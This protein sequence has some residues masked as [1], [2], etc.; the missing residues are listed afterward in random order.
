MVR[1]IATV[2]A[3]VP[4]LALAACG[5]SDEDSSSQTADE[6]SAGP[7]T[8]TIS[9]WAQGTEGEALPEFLEEFEAENPDV[10]V[11]VTAIPWDSAQN[12]YQTAIAG[13]T[14]PDIGMLGTDWMP[15]F[16]D[17]LRPTPDEIDM[18]GM[19]PANVESTNL[20]GTH[21]G[22]PWYVETRVIFY[23]TDLME[24]AGFD[25]FPTTWDGFK[26][27]ARAMQEET[28]A[29]YGVNLPAGGWN[30]FLGLLPFAWSNGA[31]ITNADQ[32]EWTFDSPEIVEAL[33]YVNGF[34]TEG[35]ADATPDDEPGAAAAAFVD[36]RI[37]MMITGPWEIGQL[38]E[39]GGD[40]FADKFAVAPIPAS[41]GSTS[42]SFTAGANLV[43]FE[44]SENPD[45]AWKLVEWLTRP[46]TQVAW[47]EATTDLPS[48][49]SAWTDKA[50]ADDPKVSVFGE[51]LQSVKTAP[52]LETWPQVSDAADSLVEQIV[53][54]GKD[55]AQAMAEL[56]STAESL[57]TG[58]D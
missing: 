26:E 21:Y 49:E 45:A 55:P 6:L 27:L 16:G 1:R 36:G 28:G 20:D 22:V 56:Q 7:A 58:S 18:S 13:G 32:T 46:E 35:I 5:R 51:Q 31:E 14:T 54:S 40:G 11:N 37:P 19:F 8:G 41:E 3:M 52:P 57:G 44:N 43:V 12:K 24:Q 50:L 25:T 17:A 23:R 29:E 2:A 53:A 33:E 48:Q 47:F 9:I 42:T 15:T 39:A 4:L 34:F 38:T 30:A 10:S